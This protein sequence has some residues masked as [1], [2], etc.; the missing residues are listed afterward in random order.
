[1]V[2]VILGVVVG[3]IVWTLL[4]VGSDAIFMAISNSYRDYMQGFETAIKTEQPFELSRMILLLTLLKSFVCS[5]ISG[6]IA[7]SIA[8]E[9]IRST[10]LL[11]VLLLAFGIFIQSVY[12]NYIPLWY[13]AS[14][15]L[16]LIPVTFLGG[17][18]WQPRLNLIGEYR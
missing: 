15:L 17:K 1:M 9:R 14:F 18:L 3:F 13:H 12:W 5:L 6:L 10:L 8:R 16:L 4:W 2:R 7:A 11:G